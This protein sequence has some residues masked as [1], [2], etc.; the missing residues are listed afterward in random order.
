MRL[1]WM[2]AIAVY[3]ALLAIAVLLSVSGGAVAFA[4]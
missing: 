4:R 1:T 2:L 3:V